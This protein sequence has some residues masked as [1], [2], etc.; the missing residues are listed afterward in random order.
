MEAYYPQLVAFLQIVLIDV[1]LAG[2][3]AVVVGMAASHLPARRR[4]QV[5]FWGVLGAVVF[6]IGFAVIATELL[7][8]VGLTLAG[9]ILL[10]WVCW[11]MYR[12]IVRPRATARGAKASARSGFWNAL[13]QIIVADVSMSLDNVLAVAGAARGQIAILVAGLALSVVLMGVVAN[14]IARLLDRHGWI[15]WI[16]LIV[17][18]QVAIEMI[19]LGSQEVGCHFGPQAICDGFAAIKNRIGTQ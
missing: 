13:A 3:N 7:A 2:D 12:E 9:G 5:I 16:G 8:I 19:W 11:K 1:V 10:L 17:I 18:L 6:R 14:L 4:S 15:A